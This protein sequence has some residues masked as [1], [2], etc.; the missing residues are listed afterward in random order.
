MGKDP[1][2]YA[3]KPD[4]ISVQFEKHGFDVILGKQTRIGV[5]IKPTLGDDYPAVL[6]QV[7]K[8]GIVRDC[9]VVNYRAVAYD[10]FNRGAIDYQS[11]KKMFA[12]NKVALIGVNDLRLE[13]TV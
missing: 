6:R 9:D 3:F 8:A 11:I 10:V 2:T 5:E 4:D 7:T 13:G 1:D 12:S